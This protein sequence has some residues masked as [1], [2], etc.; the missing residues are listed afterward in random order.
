MR[1]LIPKDSCKED[2]IYSCHIFQYQNVI[3]QRIGLSPIDAR[4]ANLLY[5]SECAKRG[6]GGGL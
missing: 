4:Q 3:G 2:R 1:H 5:R 6:G